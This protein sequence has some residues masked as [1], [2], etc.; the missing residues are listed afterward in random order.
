MGLLGVLEQTDRGEDVLAPIDQV[1]SAEPRQH[2]HARQQ[3]VADP[4]R[5]L[6][7]ARLVDALVAADR[8][9]HLML[10]ASTCDGEPDTGRPMHSG[11]GC[12]SKRTCSEPRRLPR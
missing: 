5:D 11:L 6:L 2:T 1:V 4:S 12:K 3:A 7:G 8:C 10:L 9:I